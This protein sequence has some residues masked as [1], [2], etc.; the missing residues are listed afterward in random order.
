MMNQRG[1]RLCALSLSLLAAAGAAHAADEVVQDDFRAAMRLNGQWQ[2]LPIKGLDFAYPPPAEGWKPE[3]VPHEKATAIDSAGGPYTPGGG[4]KEILNADGTGFKSDKLAAWFKRDFVLPDGVPVGQRAVLH[5]AGMAFRSET[6]FNG[7]KLG[8]SLLGQ[9]P[10]S[11]DVTALV[12]PGANQI[13]VSLAGREALVNIKEKT[14]IAPASGV[15]SGIWGDVE[16]WLLPAVHVEDVFIKT[17][18]KDKRIDLE[19]TASNASERTRRMT[20]E[21]LITDNVGNAQLIVTGEPVDLPA[22]QSKTFTITRSWPAPQLWTPESP[23]LY[24]ARVTLRDGAAL[25]DRVTERFGFREFEIRG[26]DFYLN[27]VRTVL[28]RNSF[29]T[30]LSASRE[31][32]YR[33]VRENAGRP[34]NS[35][36]LHL[37]FNAPVVLD[38]ADEIGLMMVPESAWHN[39][40]GKFQ[41]AKSELWLPQLLDYTRRLIKLHR[42]RPSVIIWSLTNETFWGDTDPQRMKIAEQV[43]E[44]ARSTDPTRP[45][46]GDGETDWGKRLPIINIHYPESTVGPVRQQYPNAAFVVPNDLYWLSPKGGKNVGWRAAFEWDRPLV[47]GEYWWVTGSVDERTSFMGESAYDWEKWRWQ[48]FGGGDTPLNN[49]YTDTLKKMTDVYRMQGVAG[50]NPW[51]GDREE[52][53]PRVA[54]RPLD[55]HPNFFAGAT[56]TRKVVVFNDTQE[57]FYD[58][59]LQC[60]L[61]VDGTTAWESLIKVPLTPGQF[62]VVDLPVAAP[63]VSRQAKGV[64]TVRLRAWRGGGYHE[65][66]RHEENVFIVPPARWNGDASGLVLLDKDGQT[67]KALGRIG[68]QLAPKTALQASDLQNART[69]IVGRNTGATTF[70]AVIEAFVKRGGRVLML[71]QDN[72]AP[73]LTQLPEPDEKHVTSRAWKRAYEHPATAGFDDAQFSYWLPDN[74][75]ATHTLH[76]PMSGAFKILLDAGGLYGLKW[77]PLVETAHGSGSIVQSQLN[78]VDR[79]GQEPLAG[80]LLLALVAHCQNAQP[81]P[82]APLRLL[83]GKNEPL[84]QVLGACSIVSTPGLAGDG[85]ILLDASYAPSAGELK[86]IKAYLTAGGRVWLHGFDPQTVSKIV[87][88]LPF[89]PEM[90]AFDPTVQ[91]AARRSSDPW[92]SNLSSYDFYWTR[93]DIGARRDFFQEGQ[94]TAKLGQYILQLPSWQAGERLIE[95][96]LLVKVPSGQGAILFDSLAWEGALGGETDKVVRLVSSLASNLGA[97]IQLTPET[98]YRYFHV[99]LTPHAARGYYDEVANDGKGGWTDQGTIDNRYFLINHSGKA[100]GM[101]VGVGEFPAQAN[102]AG[103]P[104]AL[105]N[106][107]KNNGRAVIVTRGQEHDPASPAAVPGIRVGQKADKLWFLQTAAWATPIVQQEIGRYVI[108]YEDG[109][110]AVFPLRYGVELSDWWNPLPLPASKVGWTGKNEVHSPIGIYVTEWTN[111]HPAKKIASIDLIGNLSPTQIVL[112]GITGGVEAEGAAGRVISSWNFGEVRDRLIPNRVQGAGALSFAANAPVPAQAGELKGLR[113]KGGE[114]VS[115]ETKQTP[116]LGANKPWMLEATIVPEGKPD[117][118]IGGIYQ[119]MSYMK[120]GMRLALNQEMRLTVD[121][122]IGE[123][124]T[125]YIKGQTT[126]APDRAYTVA[127]KFDGSRAYLLVNGRLDGSVDTPPPAPY[128]GPILIGTASG[129][130]YHFN[131]VI[132]EVKVSVLGE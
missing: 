9:V 69:L 127:V 83:V 58:T 92:M 29:L 129:Q 39:I 57:G 78:L 76:K 89:K 84:R 125:N 67:A 95:P 70:K 131:G 106:P 8:T 19:I 25:T 65:L 27:G 85:P 126:L 64:L 36:R 7:R 75:V 105:V 66:S 59:H 53:M 90:A 48:S 42:N 68:L 123:G 11:Y 80:Q 117:G 91:A 35:A 45:Q 41:M 38:A 102:F 124:K 61:T 21:A 121:I 81:A 73:L 46:Q 87:E 37:G 108:H 82:A 43:L 54:V 16:L 115:G 23:T 101:E 98:S 49:E 77:A 56:T 13:I 72:A 104:F 74:I 15:Q 116:E 2:T 94:P 128:S 26:T 47:M 119:A 118:Y 71:Q 18:V 88:L 32:G 97:A 107:Q 12:K 20:A 114:S 55:F 51:S 17:S 100:G 93:I 10:I 120:S 86:Q 109:S 122:V 3:T 28:L 79:V 112:L 132:G 6:W 62:Q 24:F 96:G 103:R 60:R 4:L 130:N 22:G 111:P 50:L 14:Y 33:V 5:F 52:I 113:F 30:G 99:D 63:G 110:E 44:V 34:Y 1:L 40:D 31:V